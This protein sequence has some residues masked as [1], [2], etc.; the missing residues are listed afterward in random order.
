MF[1]LHSCGF[2]AKSRENDQP[3]YRYWK[4]SFQKRRF[5]KLQSELLSF[6]MDA[7]K[8]RECELVVEAELIKLVQSESIVEGNSETRRF[9]DMSNKFRVRLQVWERFFFCVLV[10]SK[11]QS[12][13]CWNRLLDSIVYGYCWN[14]AWRTKDL[15]QL[16]FCGKKKRFFSRNQIMDWGIMKLN[17]TVK[18]ISIRGFL[19]GWGRWVWGEIRYHQ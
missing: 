18:K 8:V 9:V 16:N 15:T 10:L 13:W 14:F 12:T 1:S 5:W 17:R 4:F 6:L 19:L 7:S 2:M 11:S 3:W